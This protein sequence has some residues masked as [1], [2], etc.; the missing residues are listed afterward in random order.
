MKLIKAC[1]STSKTSQV[2][3]DDEEENMIVQFDILGLVIRC[4]LNICNLSIANVKCK[5]HFLRTCGGVSFF[6]HYDLDSSSCLAVVK[7]NLPERM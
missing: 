4:T 7:E 6:Q 2:N 3:D 5:Y 1:L